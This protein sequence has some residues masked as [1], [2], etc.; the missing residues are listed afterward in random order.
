M[1]RLIYINLIS[2]SHSKFFQMLGIYDCLWPFDTLFP[3]TK[4][5]FRVNFSPLVFV[6]FSTFLV[7]RYHWC[8]K[9]I[10]NCLHVRLGHPFI[11]PR[12]VGHLATLHK[13][14]CLRLSVKVV[15]IE[16]GSVRNL[17]SLKSFLSSQC[18]SVTTFKQEH[19]KFRSPS[20]FPPSLNIVSN[21]G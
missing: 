15:S 8:I 1:V 9:M 21:G 6:A 11:H 2:S 20:I 16:R 13:S 3:L 18:P 10:S 7:Y 17:N 4:Y 19:K 12:L 5:T 14:V